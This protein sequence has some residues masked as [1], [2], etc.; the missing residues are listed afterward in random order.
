MSRRDNLWEA[1]C[2]RR[3]A[4][5]ERNR[6]KKTPRC[7]G[8]CACMLEYV[9]VYHSTSDCLSPAACEYVRL[10]VSVDC[11]LHRLE[12][13]KHSLHQQSF[14]LLKKKREREREM[15]STRE[16]CL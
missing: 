3:L 11:V 12:N 10:L 14:K 13:I 7:G 5:G 9:A 2:T 15:R 4:M 6:K 16:G 1:I 8:G